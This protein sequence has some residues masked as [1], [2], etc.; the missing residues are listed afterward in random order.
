MGRRGREARSK[1]AK[2]SKRTSWIF[3]LLAA[4]FI[5]ACIIAAYWVI[6]PLLAPLFGIEVHHAA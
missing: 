2:V 6:I 3:R 1:G 5:L 4:V